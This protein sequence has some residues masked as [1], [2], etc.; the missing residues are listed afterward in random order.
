MRSNMLRHWRS[1]ERSEVSQHA[2][3]AARDG[4]EED[5]LY[6]EEGAPS[7]AAGSGYYSSS[8]RR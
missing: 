3:S 5:E 6:D 8:R 2:Q 1:H 4:G 7:R